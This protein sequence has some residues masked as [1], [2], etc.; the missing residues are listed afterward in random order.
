[1]TSLHQSPRHRIWIAL[2]AIAAALILTPSSVHAQSSNCSAGALLYYADDGN[3][4]YDIEQAAC[5]YYDGE[6]GVDTNVETDNDSYSDW[7]DLGSLW[8]YGIGTDASVY[9]SY[10]ANI[11]DDETGLYDSGM[12]Q[13]AT[14]DTGGDSVN[15][16]YSPPWGYTTYALATYWDSCYQ[17]PGEY[18]DYGCTWSTSDGGPFWGQW[19]TLQVAAPAPP[20]TPVYSYTITPLAGTSGYSSNGNLASY[21]D[22]VM[23]SWS[24]GYDALNRLTS[25]S[26][27]PAIQGN[28]SFAWT[29]D[30][31]GNRL[32]QTSNAGINI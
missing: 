22:S 21:T 29:Y 31:F 11:Y 20:S 28:S 12:V 23:G 13:G 4:A 25:A 19:V 14:S 10:S 27:S 15:I 24:F 3:Q 7:Q 26:A 32:T 2:I 6:S 17:I 16:N 30:S 8:I 9:A 1:M 5:I 18:D